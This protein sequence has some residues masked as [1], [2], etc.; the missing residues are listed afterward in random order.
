MKLSQHIIFENDD[1]VVINKP[2]GLLSIPDREGK[3]QSL[4]A[5]LQQAYRQ[6]FTV[7]RLD[8]DTSGV[9][10]FAKNEAAHKFLSQQFEDRQTEKLYNG[11]VIGEPAPEEGSVDAPI[12]PHPVKLGMM[13]IHRSGK[14]AL[15]DYKVL[16]SFGTYSWMEFRIHTGR[17]HQIRIHMKEIGYPLVAD[18]LYGDGKPILLSALK[19][20]FK[21]SK[22]AEEQPILGRLALHAASL[23]I[24][25][26]GNM[27]QTFVAEAPKDMRATL[28]QLEK[29]KQK[30]KR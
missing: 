23:G 11:I 27:K 15:T 22:Y 9:I 24:I 12:A 13:T 25:L 19:P 21:L 2:S 28:Q 10:I 4:K 7:H 29:I 26:P 5:L 20:K 3:E 8:K 17:T 30:K 6:I 1:L 18:E 14:A 16:D